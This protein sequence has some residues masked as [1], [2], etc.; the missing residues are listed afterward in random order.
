MYQAFN[1]FEY[2]SLSLSKLD[3]TSL[4]WRHLAADCGLAARG[5]AATLHLACTHGS[6]EQEQVLLL[7]K[8]YFKGVK[9]KNSLG[10]QI[11][12]PQGN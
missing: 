7:F 10:G 1:Q 4:E 8:V 2:G 9:R 5:D 12:P 6:R 11:C 3:S